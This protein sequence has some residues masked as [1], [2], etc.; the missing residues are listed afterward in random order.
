MA[1]AAL[2][3]ER[4]FL[5]RDAIYKSC[6]RRK[7]RGRKQSSKRVCA[8]RESAQ[9]D[10]HGAGNIQHVAVAGYTAGLAGNVGKRVGGHMR[11][12]IATVTP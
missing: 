3:W 4:P 5:R 7:G 9:T 1:K 12:T 2:K 10:A 6:P 8:G 11:L